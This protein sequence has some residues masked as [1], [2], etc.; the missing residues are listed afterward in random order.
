MRRL[1]WVRRK[2]PGDS[3]IRQ[4][5]GYDGF[6]AANHQK[7][8]ASDSGELARVLDVHDAMLDLAV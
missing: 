6:A 2:I 1:G 5:A 7:H 4:R 8:G 3:A